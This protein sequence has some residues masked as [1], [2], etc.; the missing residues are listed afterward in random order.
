[1]SEAMVQ[2]QMAEEDKLV[3]PDDI[4]FSARS[5]QTLFNRPRLTLRL[6]V[7]PVTQ[8]P[9]SPSAH[10]SPSAPA[11]SHVDHSESLVCIAQPE[12]AYGDLAVMEQKDNSEMMMNMMMMAS[13]G[14]GDFDAGND[15]DGD[16]DM[17][18][19]GMGL[20]PM[21][22]GDNKLMSGMGLDLYAS[23]APTNAGT[24]TAELL[25][26]LLLYKRLPFLSLCRRNDRTG[27]PPAHGRK[28]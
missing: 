12:P 7:L 3:L 22:S 16:D 23:A 25:V 13:G 17:G 27:G 8:S 26:L 14:G 6:R 4:H 10:G 20:M 21:A 15:D 28:D 24:T 2:K 5:L 1:M 19:D 18:G 9:S 11:P